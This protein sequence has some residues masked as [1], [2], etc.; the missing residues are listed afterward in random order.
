MSSRNRRP[1]SR[2]LAQQRDEIIAHV[3]DPA[4]PFHRFDIVGDVGSG[5]SA[6]LG[7]IAEYC[8][9]RGLLVL[10][11]AAP[12]VT[13]VVSNL[14]RERERVELDACSALVDNFITCID[15]FAQEHPRSKG[16]TSRAI[17]ALKKT[18]N[19]QRLDHLVFNTNISLSDS[20]AVEGVGNVTIGREHTLHMLRG[21]TESALLRLASECALAIVI[22]DV[23]LLDLTSIQDWLR[24]ILRRIPTR[25][26]VTARRPGSDSWRQGLAG[27][28]RTLELRN[29]TL[30]EVR[31]YLADRGHP[32]ADDEA[33]NLFRWTGGHGVAVATWCDLELDAAGT[34]EFI[35]FAD[36]ARRA[37]GGAGFASLV[38]RVQLAVDQIP[39]DVL[40]YQL[41]LFALLTIAHAVTPGLIVMLESDAGATLSAPEA[42]EIYKR[43]A[44]RRFISAV[45]GNVENGVYLSR[46]ISDVARQRLREQDPVVFRRMHA[47]AESYER[48]RVD[49]DYESK[50][51]TPFAA[52]TRFEQRT[53]IDSVV[54]WL[55]HAQWLDHEQFEKM[56]PTLVK[57]YLD[58]FWWWDDY[59]RSAATRRLR[60]AL[61]MVADQQRDVLWM[62]ALEKF[63]DHWVSSW[64]EAEL[65]SDPR[66]WHLVLEAITAL[67]AMFDLRRGRVPQDPALKRIYIL[68]C[69]FYGKALWYAGDLKVNHAKEADRWLAAAALACI[70]RHNEQDKD[71]PNGWIGSWALLRRAEIWSALDP[72]RSWGYLNGLDLKAIVDD[73]LDLRVGIA[74]LTGE[75]RWRK[76]EFAS[77]FHAYSRALL[78]SYAYNVRQESRRQAPNYYTTALYASTIRRAEKRAAEL[79][80]AGGLEVVDTALAAMRE[81]FEPYWDRMRSREDPPPA[82]RRFALPVPPPLNDEVFSLQ[83]DYVDDM[84]QL[85]QQQRD[86][87]I[88]EI[89]DVTDMEHLFQQRED[90]IKEPSSKPLEFSGDSGETQGADG[91]RIYEAPGSG[92]VI[93]DFYHQILEPSFPAT[94]L[95]DLDE[96]QDIAARDDASIWLAED[97]DGTILGG[98]VAEWDESTRV[99][100]LGYLAVRPGAR[101]S[102]IGGPLYLKA[103]DSWRQ[104]FKPCLILA[105][106]EDPVVRS[107]SDDYGDPAARLQFYINRGSRILDFPYF[108]PA[109]AEGRD[110]VSGLLL[111]VLHTDP[112][113]EGVDDGTI[114]AG[115]VREYLESYQIQYEGKVA[116]DNQAMEMWRALDRPRGIQLRA[117]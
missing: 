7:E 8:R 117:K 101:G 14:E 57:V 41:P 107:S 73:D 71:N 52:W 114:D 103:L 113:F 112:D 26:T 104:R 49:L 88:F 105:E 79:V 38:E 97:A 47:H 24:A 110:R 35:E 55:D 30:E 32:S 34:N 70:T 86:D 22:D 48:V 100:L 91:I 20:S 98:A 85:A 80:Q 102:G 62:N 23:H 94:Q 45:G 56:R 99:V 39:V 67:L 50:E 58:A 25:C 21:E 46:A 96:V 108:Q 116:T 69:N 4:V 81:L 63:S 74:V 19:P 84:E 44:S 2:R 11:V 33:R 15:T 9:D 111:L 95:I 72:Q 87:L 12:R 5:K 3:N 89:D 106:I 1:L 10:D 13:R 115:A 65:R 77:A 64:E 53:W 68:L 90:R 51:K 37:A 60:P 78:I 93:E 42:R 36:R 76:A 43:L 66:K 61:R 92:P 17:E 40:G 6:L 109:L 29:M 16:A 75:L 18:R 54:R 31:E 28:D 27:D 59:L 82:L 83:S